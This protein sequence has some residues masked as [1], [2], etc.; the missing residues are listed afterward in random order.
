[1]S[2]YEPRPKGDSTDLFDRVEARMVEPR[3][4]CVYPLCHAEAV[5]MIGVCLDHAMMV[6]KVV[7]DTLDDLVAKHRNPDSP[8]QAIIRARRQAEETPSSVVY[9]VKLGDR[10]KIGF[11]TNLDQRMRD[12]PHEEILAVVPGTMDDEKRCH[13]AFAH[14]R[15]AGEWFRA[16]PELLAFAQEVDT[17]AKLDDQ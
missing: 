16:E 7:E 8:R 11:T 13:A 6:W 4:E 15:V 5:A 1:M 3:R 9:I 14:L 17:R 10:V 12:I 2:I